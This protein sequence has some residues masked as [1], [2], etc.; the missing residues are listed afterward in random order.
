ME[1]FLSCPSF[2]CSG[3][4]GKMRWER[5]LCAGAWQT[6]DDIR[7]EFVIVQGESAVCDGQGGTSATM[8]RFHF[9]LWSYTAAQS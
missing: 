3:E 6:R 4:M 5:V 7:V 9:F 1:P 2:T 8:T